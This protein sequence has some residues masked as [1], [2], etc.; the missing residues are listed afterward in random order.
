MSTA[1]PTD[2]KWELNFTPKS[3]R[4]TACRLCLIRRLYDGMDVKERTAAS[5]RLA[6]RT[7]GLYR[8]LLTN[9]RNEG[10][11]KLADD[12]KF[13]FIRNCP[14]VGVRTKTVAGQT[15]HQWH[16]CP[17]CWVRRNVL[18]PFKRMEAAFFADKGL[19]PDLPPVKLISTMR[20]DF[21]TAKPYHEAMTVG[22]V[23]R[24]KLRL[25]TASV[26]SQR[27]GELV[28]IPKSQ[29]LGGV[30]I[31]SIDFSKEQPLRYRGGLFVVHEDAE[32]PLETVKTKYLR[33]RSTEL[34][35]TQLLYA[36]VR[37]APY[38]GGWIRRAEPSQV[39]DYLNAVHG[40]RMMSTYGKLRSH[41]H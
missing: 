16:V 9:L 11:D 8:M 29:F 39:I 24:D 27:Q 6:V 19:K 34:S 38:P 30:V 32:S 15:C 37:V 5:D 17:F 26:V 35:R 18:E 25:A 28:D 23:F 14:P 10:W 21:V 7:S 1:S 40:V 4:Q 2:I 41:S 13:Q 36:L 12:K 3:Y 20:Q 22:E 33:G 31:Q